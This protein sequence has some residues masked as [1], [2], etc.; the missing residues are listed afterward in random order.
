MNSARLS[1]RFRAS[2]WAALI[3]AELDQE[4]LFR[5][6]NFSVNWNNAANKDVVKTQLKVFQ[7]PTAEPDRV[8]QPALPADHVRL[9]RADRAHDDLPPR[10]EVHVDAGRQVVADPPVEEE[11]QR[12]EHGRHP[13]GEPHR[14][15][16]AQL[17]RSSPVRNR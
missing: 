14:Q 9:A 13:G 4:A 8:D 7:C 2:S 1:P 17:H 12:R 3:L 11:P 16:R 15:P 6:Y 5:A 10:P